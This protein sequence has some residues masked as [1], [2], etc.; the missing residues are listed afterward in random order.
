MYTS[1][2]HGILSVK[3]YL[4][5]AQKCRWVTLNIS[6]QDPEKGLLLIWEVW[7]L[8]SKPVMPCNGSGDIS[9]M[10][11]GRVSCPSQGNVA[12]AGIQV[13]G[14]R[15]N[16]TGHKVSGTINKNTVSEKT[17]DQHTS[18]PGGDPRAGPC[19]RCPQSW[20]RTWTPCLRCSWWSPSSGA[21]GWGSVHLSN[22]AS[23]PSAAS[24][25]WS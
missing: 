3:Q 16:T 21:Q 19:S 13:A 24:E 4:E 6:R 1:K 18:T 9:V 10:C 17:R 22:S 7:G 5:K 12:S 2:G 23:P 11:D 15:G 25:G 8:A 14:R 20:W